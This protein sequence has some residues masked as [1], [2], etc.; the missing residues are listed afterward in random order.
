MRKGQMEKLVTA[1][2]VIIIMIVA[3]LFLTF[4]LKGA[5]I[6]KWLPSKIKGGSSQP[7]V[8]KAPVETETFINRPYLIADSITN[9]DYNGRRGID[10]FY[11]MWLGNKT[12]E[13]F[14]NFLKDFLDRYNFHY[15]VYI[16]E[17]DEERTII[18]KLNVDIERLE[19]FKAE[20]PLLYKNRVGKLVVEVIT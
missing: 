11:E 10:Y 17:G 5:K 8:I 19:S 15:I 14:K 6:V 3:G 16:K 12:D 13:D 20:T 1:L 4:F 7:I 18:S 2:F 9:L